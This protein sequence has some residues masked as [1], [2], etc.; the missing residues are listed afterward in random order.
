ML[1]ARLHPGKFY[2]YT[3]ISYRATCFEREVPVSGGGYYSGTS[4]EAGSEPPWQVSLRDGVESLL[5][6]VPTV[7]E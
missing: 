6:S 4:D 3:L 1:A 5:V 2:T 7:C